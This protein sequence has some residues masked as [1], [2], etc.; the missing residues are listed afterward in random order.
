MFVCEQ[1]KKQSKKGDPS[2]LVVTQM[3]PVEY[4][5]RKDANHF[6]SGSREEWR[7][8]PG[9]KGLGIAKVE[10]RCMACAEGEVQA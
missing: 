7:D 1:C 6:K 4:P 8:D 3:K 5:Y 9:G 10:R 2:C